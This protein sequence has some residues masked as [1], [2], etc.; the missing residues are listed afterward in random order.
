MRICIT[1]LTVA[2]AFSAASADVL[3]GWDFVANA[4]NDASAA[5][6]TVA[7]GMAPSAVTRGAGLV[8]NTYIDHGRQIN[9]RAWPTFTAELTTLE[10]L[11]PSAF[12]G[13]DYF[14]FTVDPQGAAMS[15]ESVVMYLFQQDGPDMAFELQWATDPANFGPANP[16]SSG[17]LLVPISNTSSVLHTVDLTGRPELQAS[18]DAWEFRLYGWGQGNAYQAGGIGRSPEGSNGLEVTGVVPEPA[19]LALL[20]LGGLLIRRRR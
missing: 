12:S 18:T 8:P 6:S 3:L 2:L 10:L 14:T 20:G 19:S 17:M 4:A 9:A 15:L 5:A 7:A 11:R 1:I 16:N 13:N